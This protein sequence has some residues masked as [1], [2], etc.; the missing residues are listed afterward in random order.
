MRALTASILI[1]FSSVGWAGPCDDLYEFGCKNSTNDKVLAKVDTAFDKRLEKHI[2]KAYPLIKKYLEKPENSRFVKTIVSQFQVKC[3][4]A[5]GMCAQKVAQ[6][7]TRVMQLQFLYEREISR[8]DGEKHFKDKYLSLK[9]LLAIQDNPMFKKA[10]GLIAD[11]M[12]AYFRSQDEQKRIAQEVFPRVKNLMIQRL[13]NLDM[14]VAEKKDVIQKIKAVKFS[15]DACKQLKRDIFLSDAFYSNAAFF[16][17]TNTIGFCNGNFLSIAK[18]ITYVQ[19]LAHELGHAI[20]PCGYPKK[21]PMPELV[22]CLRGKKSIQ[23]RLGDPNKSCSAGNDQID[24]A[25]SDW[26]A[27]E[28]TA[29]YTENYYSELET[30]QIQTLYANVWSDDCGEPSGEVHPKDRLR[31]NAILMTQ[32]KIR[33][34]MGC[35]KEP[36]Q[37]Q[38]CDGK[39]TQSGSPGSSTKGIK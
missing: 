24:E 31:A 7:F 10:V 34:Q 38:Y 1:L 23:A 3:D 20:D 4:F 17:R 29:E 2:L 6:L 27:A 11:D 32:P 37:Y 33:R 13:E 19:V 14:S 35:T 26:I 22:Q 36:T 5:T 25:F 12:N 18:Q 30:K 21:F 28:V 39:A 9:G 15:P 8:Y 16:S